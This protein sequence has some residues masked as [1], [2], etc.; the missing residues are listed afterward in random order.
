MADQATP[1]GGIDP[2]VTI[3]DGV[4]AAS[5]AADQAYQA[6][7]P[8][9]VPE[10]G[11]TAP[12]PEPAPEP[13]PET[14]LE[15]QDE[16]WE[17][18]YK[19]MKGRYDTLSSENRNLAG[20]LGNLEQTLAKVASQS[21]NQ[22]RDPKN[23]PTLDQLITPQEVSDYGE[24][25]LNIVEKKA[26]Q[27]LMPHLQKLE[28]ENQQLKTQLQHVGQHVVQDAKGKLENY[29][30]TNLKTWRELNHNEEFLGWLAQPDSYSG[31]KRHDL[32][33]QAYERNDSQRV[34]AFFNGFLADEAV[35]APRNSSA[36]NGNGNNS[37]PPKVPLEKFAAPGRARTAAQ[38]PA[39]KPV[40]TRGQISAFYAQVASGGYSGNEA[41]KVRLENMIFEA[42][43][44]GRIT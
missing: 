4:K 33:T 34:L 2:G 28:Q 42:Q 15:S 14:P 37:Q 6:A 44:D 36:A 5:A 12:A 25:F 11:T 29:L 13:T 16:G 17:R 8:T 30:D 22:P 31:A 1:E 26:K 32:L 7:Y 23:D 9:Q 3:P 39:E 27:A 40:I 20:R 35:V 38:S 19:A 24:E 43:R 18:R 10:S 21:S 41:E